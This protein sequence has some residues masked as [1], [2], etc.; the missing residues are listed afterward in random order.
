MLYN[1]QKKQ[2]P[3]DREE[4]VPRCDNAAHFCSLNELSINSCSVVYVTLISY[5]VPE[6]ANWLLPILR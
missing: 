6:I 2:N 3:C 5:F 1:F 4:S